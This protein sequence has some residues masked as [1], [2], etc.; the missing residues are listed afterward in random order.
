MISKSPKV[1][2]LAFNRLTS[3]WA[4]LQDLGGIDVLLP[5]GL[6][7]HLGNYSQPDGPMTLRLG[8]QSVSK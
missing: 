5:F 7:C 4:Q 8:D 1:T 6:R 2:T 3:T